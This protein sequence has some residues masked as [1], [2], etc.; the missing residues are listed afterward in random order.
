MRIEDNK[1]R[2]NI[3]SFSHDFKS[4]RLVQVALL[5]WKRELFLQ[6]L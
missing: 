4:D 5:L 1:Q 6:I 3:L 2:K